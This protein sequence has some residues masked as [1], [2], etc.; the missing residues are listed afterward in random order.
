MGVSK[1]II[2]SYEGNYE[3]ASGAEAAG[4]AGR[5]PRQGGGRLV[6]FVVIFLF[7]FVLF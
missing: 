2:G 7:F 1:F 5:G 4:P 3:S 6:S